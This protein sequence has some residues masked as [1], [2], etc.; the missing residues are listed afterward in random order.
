M[1]G[2]CISNK[3][4]KLKSTYS[5]PFSLIGSVLSK[6]IRDRCT[7]STIFPT[8]LHPVIEHLYTRSNFNSPISKSFD[9]HE[10]N[11]H[12]LCLNRTL[13]LAAWEF[14]GN[15]I[16]QKAYQAKLLKILRVAEN[17]A[18]GIITK[19]G[20]ETGVAGVF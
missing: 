12:T 1:D 2:G 19:W 8:M 20:G 17:Q 9:R 18:H 10:P 6:A 4:E 16:L 3:L 15:S 13:A 14:S 11:H 7:L 5:P